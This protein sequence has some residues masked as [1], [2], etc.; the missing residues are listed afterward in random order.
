MKRGRI[1]IILFIII[2]FFVNPKTMGNI[3]VYFNKDKIKVI[4]E[5]NIDSNENTSILNYKNNLI[6]YDGKYLKALDEKGQRLFDLNIE[7]KEFYINSSKY[8][9]I[10]DKHNK[11]A[12]SINNNGTIVFKKQF[13]KTPI[14]FKS[15]NEKKFIYHYKYDKNEYIDLYE[16]NNN[17]IKTIPINGTL[18][19]LDIVK[20][21]IVLTYINTQDNL[22]SIV[23][24]YDLKGNIIDTN[25]FKD[26]LFI[27]AE[28]LNNKFYCV[29]TNSIYILNDN[30]KTT[31]IINID[32]NINFVGNTKKYIVAI[33]DKNNL[34]HIDDK[35]EL[36]K[37]NVMNNIKGI[38]YYDNS[39]IVY[40]DNEIKNTIDNNKH[41]FDSK[42]Y[43]IINISDKT[44]AILQ[45]KKVSLIYI[46]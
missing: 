4:K 19:D 12:Y 23:D 46:N 13:T 17:K 7:S 11:I 28:Y 1:I 24:K 22:V 5:F 33:D 35:L 8:I 15:I 25:K 45:D 31:K 32:N 26:K 3:K 36:K 2:V 6:L 27:E 14:S 43:K 38:S 10:L 9:D 34:M 40:D 44:I 20:N 39:Y 30:L 29:D 18:T 21:N 41:E 42:I 37:K 16:I